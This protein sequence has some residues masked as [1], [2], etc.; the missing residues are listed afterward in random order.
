MMIR[1]LNISEFSQAFIEPQPINLFIILSKIVFFVFIVKLN[2]VFSV[3]KL[4]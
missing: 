1:T 3:K 4:S 2:D